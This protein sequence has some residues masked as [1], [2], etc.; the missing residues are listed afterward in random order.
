MNRDVEASKL[1][2]QSERGSGEPTTSGRSTN[3]VPELIKCFCGICETWF[4]RKSIEYALK[5]NGEAILRD[6]DSRNILKKFIA[7]HKAGSNFK[8]P[9]EEI[10]ECFELVQDILNGEKDLEENRSDLDDLCYTEYWEDNLTKAIDDGTTD[11]YFHD[12]I[13]ESGIRLENSKEYSMFKEEL[14]KKLKLK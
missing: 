8:T 9:V 3:P 2:L 11:D 14:K 12:L 10:I 13:R 1:F 6:G 4:K 7:Y 5:S